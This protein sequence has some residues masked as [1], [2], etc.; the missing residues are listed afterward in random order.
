MSTSR[1]AWYGD[2]DRAHHISLKESAR[3][4]K[5]SD[6][7]WIRLNGKALSIFDIK[8]LP[9]TLGTVTALID[10]LI[11]NST[12]SF[13]SCINLVDRLLRELEEVNLISPQKLVSVVRRLEDRFNKENKADI[14]VGLTILL[15]LADYA[16]V[17]I[18]LLLNNNTDKEEI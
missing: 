16:W 11:D 3:L 17:K 18:D 7:L 12:N 4:A 9:Q 6:I 13:D 14:Y 8:E 15:K 10:A 5:S 1:N 2:F